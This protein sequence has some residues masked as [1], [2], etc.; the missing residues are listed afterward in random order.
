MRFGMWREETSLRGGQEEVTV[1]I[2]RFL[3]SCSNAPAARVS[4]ARPRG[5]FWPE[6]SRRVSVNVQ[7]DVNMSTELNTTLSKKQQY[8]LFCFCLNS[9]AECA[10]VIKSV[11]SNI[12]LH[13]VSVCASKLVQT[14]SCCGT[15]TLVSSC[16]S[17]DEQ[18]VLVIA[19]EVPSCECLKFSFRLFFHASG[20]K[21]P[22]KLR[23]S[24]LLIPL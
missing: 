8:N 24:V 16:Y 22:E 14:C 21:F 12:R 18:T 17:Q 3:A 10:E 23:L 2:S 5:S 15:D 7:S 9:V 19:L 11:V 1:K 4:K 6:C 13:L 20:P